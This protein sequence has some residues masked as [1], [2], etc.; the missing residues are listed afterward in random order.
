[1]T[2]I[3]LT[4]KTGSGK[5]A[6]CKELEKHGVYIIDT[7]IIARKIVQK[8]MPALKKLCSYFGDGILKEDKT[9]DRKALAG[10]AFSCEE[11]TKKLNEITHPYINEEVKNEIDFAEKNGYDFCVVDA[12]ALLE[13]ECKNFCD[14]IAVVSASE[15]TRLK[16]IL[17]RDFI[18]ET[19]AM[20]RI[21]A[22]KEDEYYFQN[23]DIIIMNENSQ[24]VEDNAKKLLDFAK[25][26][27]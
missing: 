16:R 23:A 26:K 14:F 9:L 8:G 6:V 12:A 17:A 2:V 1:M 13:S 22:Q 21:R 7:D 4:G 15:E 24:S 3:G 18:D 20:Q 25:G 5:S 11:N 10:I 19:S 27:I